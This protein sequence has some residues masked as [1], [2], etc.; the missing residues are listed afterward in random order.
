M[1]EAEVLWPGCL[2]ELTKDDVTS[3]KDQQSQVGGD[4][5]FEHLPLFFKQI[6]ILKTAGVSSEGF[7]V[8]PML[9]SAAELAGLSWSY[10]R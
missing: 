8:V 5:P 2:S 10:L 7:T 1:T 6:H 3:C 9:D 4:V